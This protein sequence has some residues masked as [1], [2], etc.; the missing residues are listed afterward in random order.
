M[1]IYEPMGTTFIQTRPSCL[2]PKF[3]KAIES[4]QCVSDS[5]SLQCD[6]DLKALDNGHGAARVCV[7]SAR[8]DLVLV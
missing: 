7:F 4:M 2:A 1:Q 5:L 6:R 8:F 3:L